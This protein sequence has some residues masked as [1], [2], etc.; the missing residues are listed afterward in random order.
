M[1]VSPP[2]QTCP[3]TARRT[4]ARADSS[5]ALAASRTSGARPSRSATA[6]AASAAGAGSSQTSRDDE[7]ADL[8]VGRRRRPGTDRPLRRRRTRPARRRRA[9]RRARRRRGQQHAHP[10]RTVVDPGARR[11]RARSSRSA[12]AIAPVGPSAVRSAATAVRRTPAGSPSHP[13]GTSPAPHSWTMAAP[14]GGRPLPARPAQNPGV[15][16]PANGS[17]RLGGEDP[18]PV[19]R[20]GSVGGSRNVVSDRL[21]QLANAAICRR[22]GRRR[23]ARRRRD[24]RAELG[25]EHVDLGER[26]HRASLSSRCRPPTRGAS[27]ALDTLVGMPAIGA[28]THSADPL[29]GG[30]PVRRRGGAVLPRRSAGLE[31]AAAPPVRRGAGRDRAGQV[32]ARA[33]SGERG[34]HQQP[35]PD[36]QPQDPRPSM[37]PA[38]L[39]SAPRG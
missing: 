21:V 9:G 38:P 29:R 31:E 25:G 39:R 17:S 7:R 5:G 8:E 15:G 30:G 24:C 20:A 27:V 16:W 23:R 22:R 35:H 19:V 10:A 34:D 4:P 1:T 6:S 26:A 2:T 11:P 28:H 18:Q 14:A 36:P 32:R 3:S 12:A 37:R 13:D 33:V